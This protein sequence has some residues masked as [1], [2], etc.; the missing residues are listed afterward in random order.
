MK[1]VA[2]L[3]LAVLVGGC[4]GSSG[5][6]AVSEVEIRHLAASP[7]ERVL[8]IGDTVQ[9]TARLTDAG[10]KALT[11]RKVTWESTLPSVASV[12]QSG[13]VTALSSGETLVTA[14]A[15]GVSDEILIV[16]PA[17]PADLVCADGDPGV[18]L[19]VGQAHTSI[20]MHEQVVCIAGGSTGSE[21]V[22]VPF[23][24]AEAKESLNVEVAAIGLV[25][26]VGPPS[27]ALLAEPAATAGMRVP[28]LVEDA[29]FHH[30]L[31]ARERRELTPLVGAGRSGMSPIFSLGPSYATVP[32]MGDTMRFNV[33]SEEA[34][35]EPKY[36]AGVVMAISDRA[37]VVADTSNP[38]GGFTADE[39][40]HFAAT[41][42]T[43]VYPTV[44]SN[45]AMPSDI[46][47]NGQRSI[48]LF[49]KA[50]NEL[51][52]SNSES[53]VGGFFYSR[54][55]FPKT[56]TA[57]M[58]GCSASN[59]AEMFYMLVPDPNGEVNGNKRSKDFVQERTVGVLA[60]EFQHLVNAAHRLFVVKAGGQAWV[61]E[62]WLNEGLSHI[63]EELTF[64][65][66]TP[67]GPRQ[68][69]GID[70]L[71]SGPVFDRFVE[72]QW[73]NFGRYIAYLKKAATQSPLGFD[74]ADQD[75]ETR[76]A[77]WAFLRYSADRKGGTE[78]ALWKSMV[79]TEEVGISNLN[80]ALGN[81]T[82]EWME[83]WSSSVYADDAVP[84]S[85]LYQQPSWNF[86]E[87][88]TSVKGQG[89]TLLYPTYPLQVFQLL[90]GESNQRALQLQRGGAAFLRFGVPAGGR[91]AVRTTSGGMTPP[92]RLG[93]TIVRTK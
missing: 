44:T 87:I 31:R 82:L 16:V 79:D 15:E 88:I 42:D 34:C 38:A 19:A 90:S 18:S 83:D 92:S 89:G 78:S 85:P 48:I 61:E 66:S 39:Y 77:I 35:T 59:A 21:Y 7:D 4:D 8:E 69:I 5:P 33:N 29:A 1:K 55:L 23:N 22:M 81:Q 68:N 86:R 13:L 20:P 41:F 56:G 70:D 63:A 46:D 57:T 60:H 30:E 43:L 65:A 11:G 25:A 64:Y 58:S 28:R 26:S 84:T 37:V 49:T 45:F 91:A 36:T 17:P 52:P 74:A 3:G 12:S 10:G 75:L 62:V 47:D 71:P 54:D 27:P 67:L 72:Y 93:V 53:Y 2:F 14:T 9:L 76:G 24:S 73:S 32:V 51:T 40:A 50:V 6:A 80:A